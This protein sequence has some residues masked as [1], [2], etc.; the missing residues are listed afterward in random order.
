MS[1]VLIYN[2]EHNKN[3]KPIAWEGVSK[4][5]TRSEVLQEYKK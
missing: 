1:S 4:L 2:A 5:F 3:K